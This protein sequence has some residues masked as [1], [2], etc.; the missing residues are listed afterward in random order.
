MLS[1][2]SLSLLSLSLSLY[3]YILLLKFII[4]QKMSERNLRQCGFSEHVVHLII[5]A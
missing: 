4:I 5:G 2:Y 1:Y 3:F